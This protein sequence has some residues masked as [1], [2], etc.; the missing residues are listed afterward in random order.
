MEHVLLIGLST[1]AAAGA[2]A[3][4][5]F[6]VT[7]L[8]AF[9]DLDQH[10]AVR[11]IALPR[12]SG[13]FTAR[14]AC[15]AASSLAA[16]AVAYLSPFENHP[17]LVRRLAANRALLGNSAEVLRRVR[18]P[19]AVAGTFARHGFAAPLT[20]RESHAA[21]GHEAGWLLKPVASGGGT[22][23]REWLPASLP[24]GDSANAGS[25]P[26]R[27]YLQ[28]R[29]DG[30]AGSIAFVAARGRAVPL[31]ISLQLTGDQAFAADGYR[32]CGSIRLAPGDVF[33]DRTRAI[34]TQLADCAAREFGLV[35]LNGIDFI[36]R[37][38][39]PYPIEINPRWSASMEL[40]ERHEPGSAF[41]AHARACR[42]GQLP[43]AASFD[44][45][46]GAPAS[47]KAIAFATGHLVIGDTQSWLTDHWRHDIP[48]PG[49][50]IEAGQPICTVF[51]EGA[52]AARCRAGLVARAAEVYR[53]LQCA[54]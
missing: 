28:E 14:A 54:S 38:E 36:V 16:D 23:I 34:A 7:A 48:R 9:A 42:D 19:V 44:L 30:L 1:R 13:A 46:R 12:P 33:S 21:A 25:V 22:R 53:A 49:E 41:A 45:P 11:A 47:G 15:Y 10:P 6:T 40:A 27:Y 37:D 20:V 8:D 17:A 5:G 35:G 50:Q 31:G 43:G 4:A 24:A 26:R 18:D 3:H 2:A 29:I 51:A 32:Y 39:V 52:D